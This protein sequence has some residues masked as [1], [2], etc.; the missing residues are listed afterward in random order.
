MKNK[1]LSLIL[2]ILLL[3]IIEVSAYSDTLSLQEEK[4][5]LIDLDAR[6]DRKWEKLEENQLSPTWLDDQAELGLYGSIYDKG[7]L[8]PRVS[9]KIVPD[10]ESGFLIVD[11]LILGEG[12]MTQIA[13]VSSNLLL[14]YYFP[15]IQGGPVFEKVFTRITPVKTYKE[16]LL[17]KTYNI[18]TFPFNYEEFQSLEIGE[19]HSTITT[20]GFFTRLSAGI[21]DM[22]GFEVP[23]PINLGPKIKYHFKKSIKVSVTKE[24]DTEIVIALEDIKEQMKGA[25]IGLGVYFEEMINLPVSIGID[26]QNGYSPLVLNHKRTTQ[27]IKSLVYKIDLT[28]KEGLSAYRAFLRSDLTKIQ[29]LSEKVN[30]PVTLDIVKEG[31]VQTNESN[32]AVNLILYRIGERN[33]SV[34]GKFI[35]KL[36]NDKEFKYQEI[37]RKRVFDR[38]T[39]SGKEKDILTFSS[40]VPED[41]KKNNFVL[42]TTYYY[43]DTEAYGKE[44]ME[45][46]KK[47]SLLGIPAGLPVN[48]NRDKDYGKI[49]LQAKLR[50]DS[51]AIKKF[52]NSPISEHWISIASAFGLSDPYVWENKKLR[53][54]FKKK[55]YVANYKR[56]RGHNA[57]RL[58]R[59]EKENLEKLNLLK[60]AQKIADTITEIN[61]EENS[62]DKAKILIK[63]LYKEKSGM[64]LHK[65][66]VDTVGEDS[67]MG[68]G[69]IRGRGL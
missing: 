42:D 44:L 26:G 7:W 31:V 30:S 4:Q 35:T 9:R 19:I 45:I 54:N 38:K 62:V 48:F 17:Y 41:L 34:T 68:R 55:F 10:L 28:S 43:E 16:A 51:T 12:I 23:S 39:F 13:S 36:A 2:A 47:I 57:P 32:F 60:K 40:I 37:T 18:Q 59:R 24:S 63:E 64:I 5:I 22:L 1:N 61:K 56:K 20:N 46:S 49:Q 8:N 29:D 66:M 33:I 3:F 69:Y 58:S 14:G 6:A 15:Y 27:K 52:F 25:G 67:I 21:F 65:V 11:R 53:E 50:F